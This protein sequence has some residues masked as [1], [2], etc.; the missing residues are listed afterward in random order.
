MVATV[1]GGFVASRETASVRMVST[2]CPLCGADDAELLF[3]GEDHNFG[4][5]GRFPVVRCRKC[6]LIYCNPFVSPADVGQFF[7]SGYAAHDVEPA[8]AARR[9][10]R[11]VWDRVRPFGEARLLDLGCGGGAFLARMRATG[12]RGLGVDPVARAIESC[13]ALGVEAIEGAIP[14][15]DL[16]ARRFELITL[17]GSLPNLPKPRETFEVLR[18]HA[19]EGGRLVFNAFNVEGWLA[20]RCGRYWLGYD[21]PRQRCHYSRVTV[22]RLLSETGWRVERV[23]YRRRP[24]LAR[25]NAKLMALVTGKSGWRM[26]ASQKWLLSGLVTLTAWLQCSDEMWVRARAG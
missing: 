12:W 14:G 23:G 15:V 10:G 25:R 22:E 9:R 5:A 17:R 18:Q 6:S 24:N 21:L 3:E 11:D 20:Q 13:R 1:S 2:A 7:D 4:F 8:R 16:G 26:L 19:A